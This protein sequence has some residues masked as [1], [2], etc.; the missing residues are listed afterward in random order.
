MEYID[1]INEKDEVIDS[2]RY[3]EIYEKL[4]P[5]RIV[6]ILV[7]NDRGELLLQKRS[8]NKSFLPLFWVT[9]AGGHV[10]SGESYKRGAMREMEEELGLVEDLKF[11]EK[12]RYDDP[13]GFFKFLTTFKVI[14]NGPFDY[15]PEEVD[16]VKFFSVKDVKELVYSGEKFHP[17]LLFVLNKYVFID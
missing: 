11:L 12:D 5:H 14:N 4:L 13:R 15:D 7:F 6:H 1:I 3:D 2:V 17:E 10:Q 16:S 8:E 9:S